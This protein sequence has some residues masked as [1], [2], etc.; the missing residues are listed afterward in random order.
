MFGYFICYYLLL[1]DSS[2]FVV[3]TFMLNN[4]YFIILDQFS[5]GILPSA[6]APM[7]NLNKSSLVFHCTYASITFV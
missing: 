5:H 3:V 6:N 4:Q 7:T 1:K 2:I